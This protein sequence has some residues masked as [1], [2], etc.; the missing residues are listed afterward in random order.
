M[1]LSFIVQLALTLR[2]SLESADVT[3]LAKWLHSLLVSSVRLQHN[4]IVSHADE[5]QHKP[6]AN[7]IVHFGPRQIIL[8]LSVL[9]F[10]LVVII[11]L[12]QVKD[13]KLLDEMAVSMTG[14]ANKVG[15]DEVLT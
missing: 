12:I 8:E 10:E 15:L 11:W 1:F 9:F 14:L 13:G 3:T 6:L 4:V 2:A 5:S 7:Q